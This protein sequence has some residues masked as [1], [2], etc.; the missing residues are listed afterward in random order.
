MSR[1][2]PWSEDLK[3]LLLGAAILF[4]LVVL[5]VPM[6][7]SSKPPAPGGDQSV[8]LAIPPAPD[9]DLQ[10]K[11]MNLTP[12]AGVGAP[13]TAPPTASASTAHPPVTAVTPGPGNHLATVNIG[14]NRPRDVET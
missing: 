7:F 1:V 4:A 13:S 12:D 14:S 8:S 10:T 6:F 2:P 5:F 3:S 11:T 9:R